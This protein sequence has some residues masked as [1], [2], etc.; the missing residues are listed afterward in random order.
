MGTGADSP[1]TPA[2]LNVSF[3]SAPHHAGD[4]PEAR[5]VFS[6]THWSLVQ[7][8]GGTTSP[9]AMAALNTLAQ[10]YWYPLYAY[11]R[12]R[13]YTPED[14]QDLT[15]SFFAR[16]LE[17]NYVRLADARRG[18]FRTFLL[19][20]LERFLADEW[21][22]TRRLKRGGGVAAVSFD[23]LTAEDRYQIEPAD[24][25][26]AARL[27]DRRW[28]TTLLDRAMRQLEAEHTGPGRREQFESLR[29]FLA[30]DSNSANYAEF[31][32]RTG[33]TVTAARMA[34]SRLRERYG[35][36]L[37][38]EILQTVATAQDAEEEFRSLMAALR[39]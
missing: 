26:D 29:A 27:F 34:V 28:A 12:R 30:V 20:S 2:S 39:D 11:V 13:G 32:D 1:N 6:T 4:L 25:F 17:K 16:L 36:V 22:R 10:G 38:E 35:E 18:K 7:A 19:T 8:A 14:A 33:M 23:A 24:S 21:D 3:M 37:R 15:Q 31:A 9:E 5:A